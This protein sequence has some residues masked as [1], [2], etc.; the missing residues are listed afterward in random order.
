[1]SEI[2]VYD[3]V[4]TP[5]LADKLIGTSVGGVIEDVTYNFTLQELLQLF[6]P[7]LPANNLQ[8]V[9]NYGNTA[10]QNINLTGTINTT[11]LNVLATAN[12]LNSNLSG[13]TRVMAGLF[14]RTNA[15]GTAGQFLR[16][17]GTQVEWFTIPTV[18]PT[19]QQV[20]QSGNTSNIS[21]VLT[22]NITAV[23]ATAATVVSN[24]SLNVNGVLRDGT[25]AAGGSNQILSSTGSGVRWVDMPVYN[26]ISPL[27]YDTPTKTFSIQVANGSQNG[28]LSSAD[29][30]NF[31]GKQDAI[32]LTT[33]GTSGAATFAANTLNIPVYTPDLSGYVPTSRTLTINGVT[34]DL[35][36]NRSWTIP[37]GVASVT[38][39][40]P[41]SSSG[42][43][44]PDISIQVA[45]TLQ[46]GYLTNTDWNTFNAKQ[47]ALTLTT[48][49]T[50]GPSTLVG[51]TLNIPQ[52]QSVLTNPITGSGTLNYVSK[53]TS[54][55]SI[56][57]S[58][59]QDS[60][61][62]ITLGSNT[63]VSSG[64]LAIGATNFTGSSLRVGKNITGVVTSYGI[65][66]DGSVDSDVT[67]ALN[68]ASV[69]K[70]SAASFTLPTYNHFYAIQGTFGAGSTV[71]TQQGFVATSTLIGATTNIGFR[72]DIPAGTGRWNLY[73]GGTAINYMSGALLIGTTTD[74]GY[75]LDVVGST[76]VSSSNYHRYN[77][78]T[79]LFGSGS[80]INGGTVSQ[81]GIRAA[82]DILFATN[83]A[84]ERMR[85][86]SLGSVGI[87]TTSLTGYN[88][89][90]SKSITGATT[91]YGVS[92][93]GTIQSD[94]TAQGRGYYTNLS[95]AASAF[96]LFALTHFHAEQATIGAGSTVTTQTGFL[97]NSTLIGATT[98]YGFRGLIASGTNRWNLFMDGTANNHLAGA[99]GI[100]T[101]S[102]T[103]TNLRVSKNIT[104][105]S[106]S[107]GIFQN[108]VVQSDVTSIAYSYYSSMSTSAA[109]FSVSNLLHFS[110][111]QGTLGAGS[112]ASVQTGFYVDNTLIGATNNYGFRGQIASGANRYNIY[113]DGTA[114]NYLAGNL[115][116]GSTTDN[117]I[118]LQV[119][120]QGYFSDSVGIGPFSTV[121]Y[122]LRVS[123]DVT[124]S[125][126]AVSIG[127]DGTIKSD[128]TTSAINYR[129]GLTTDAASF[130]LPI[131]YHF[132][133]NQGTIGAGSAVTSQIAYFVNANLNGA[134]SN[135]G[136]YGNLASAT[137]AWNLYMNGT[138]NNYINGDTAI[139]TTTLGTATK[140]TVGGTETASSAI[141]RGQLLNTTLV[142]S[143][144]NDV[145]VGLD[146]SPT[147]TN[148]AF[149]GVT[150][151][152]LRTNGAAQIGTQ[153]QVFRNQ[154]VGNVD[155]NLNN[156]ASTWQGG[157][158]YRTESGGVTRRLTLYSGGAAGVAVDAL[159]I[160]SGGN[161][162]IGST[163]DAGFRLDVNG[164]AR[165][166]GVLT[167]TADA[168]I[169]GLTVGRGAGNNTSNTAIGGSALPANTSSRDN[170]VVGYQAMFRNT[171]GERNTA[172]GVLTLAFNISGNFNNAF[173][174]GALFAST[175]NDNTAIGYNSLNNISSG[176]NNV[177]IGN[178][179]GS[180]IAA[181]TSN[182][183]SNNSIFIGND[184][185]ASANGQTN[186]IV[187]GHTAIGL[188]SNTTVL[189]NS[190]TTL[191]AL[192]GS[193]I[194]GGTS[195]NASAQ[196]QVDSTTKGFLP[197][198]MT[199]AQRTAIASPA[200]GLI[201]YQTD[202]VE[203]LWLRVSTGWVEL[204][205]V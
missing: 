202:G 158:Y 199:A 113:M 83:G 30:I 125:V 50:S 97:A 183:T 195:V 126:N 8:G 153:L 156:G 134:T 103:N 55:S 190:S 124:G 22:A 151:F 120:G 117:G 162:V 110:A 21:I 72:G 37:A 182:G 29:W 137:N 75:K 40:S 111:T 25:A 68:Y 93:D 31:D 61:T 14:D 177:S 147:F 150:N 118:K 129:S 91:S 119:T 12:I 98:N 178:L 13:N 159:S 194:T 51:D 108:G 142:A 105:G 11:N 74:A 64:S 43:A 184:T 52:Y 107:L 171:T 96:T 18:I 179:S 197:P 188:G 127:T 144:N 49:G 181:G 48:T 170:T 17:T 157:M 109:S 200:T 69:S 165:V 114:N 133:A 191:T 71:T 59:I 140:L 28:Y 86:S 99:L 121:G 63:F 81:L 92:V 141:A 56:G 123:K 135:F 198:R 94:V 155:L 106:I 138:A 172:V 38:A 6:I 180:L 204:T 192:Y 65:L 112:S 203:G 82:S 26:V 205:V 116:I 88:L 5:K 152:T 33:T 45:N 128:V 132:S 174:I 130:T 131:F 23:T 77:G 4:P 122:G 167:T 168:V 102:L 173:G 148:G 3:I 58:N 19:L 136:F 201:V 36:A 60:G 115:L 89:R 42:G 34:Y 66:A 39:T 15:S 80:A 90:V 44:N 176:N 27:L 46:S 41:L 1:M 187:I 160:F 146:I 67:T 10:T 101:T 85:I 70:T 164:T 16:S 62:L 20:L 193:V 166:Q 163:T 24:T 186:Q 47:G 73:M 9:L 143:A 53:F 2:S 161:I 185:R 169:N 189:G 76:N 54:A 139:G 35:S 7:N 87:G 149:T 95:T 79:G 100:G 104:G 196:F 84:N 57:D 32:I 78:D 175:G 154:L 145:L